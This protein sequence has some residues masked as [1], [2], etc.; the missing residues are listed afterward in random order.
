MVPVVAGGVVPVP[1]VAGGVVPVPVVAG[2]V[3]AGAGVV[4]TMATLSMKV[5][6]PAAV[7]IVV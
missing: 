1:V 7:F 6:G 4:A 5:D 3:A 2:G